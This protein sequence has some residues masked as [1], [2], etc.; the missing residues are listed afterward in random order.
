MGYGLK[1]A[2]GRVLGLESSRQAGQMVVLEQ[3]FLWFKARVSLPVG[4]DHGVCI[5]KY[6]VRPVQKYGCS[7]STNCNGHF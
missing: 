3:A 2:L 4:G 6:G 1:D 7:S 5:A